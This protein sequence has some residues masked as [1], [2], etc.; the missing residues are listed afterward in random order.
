MSKKQ[1]AE[2]IEQYRRTKMGIFVCENLLM[3]GQWK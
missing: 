1:L 3:A 2:Y